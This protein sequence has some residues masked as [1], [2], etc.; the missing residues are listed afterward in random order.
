[1]G[2]RHRAAS[3]IDR[4]G[5]FD[6]DQQLELSRASY[7]S[8]LT[9]L[10]GAMRKAVSRAAVRTAANDNTDV[11]AWWDVALWGAAVLFLLA[12]FQPF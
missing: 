12:T 2:G 11:L 9:V 10:E 3:V 8:R 6:P 5:R 7:V 1:M 4:R